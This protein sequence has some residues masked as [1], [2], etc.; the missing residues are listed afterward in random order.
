MTKRY[1]TLPLLC[2]SCPADVFLCFIK[3]SLDKVTAEEQLMGQELHKQ[4]RKGSK[5]QGEIQPTH[6]LIQHKKKTSLSVLERQENQ[7]LPGNAG[8]CDGIQVWLFHFHF[9][10]QRKQKLGQTT[11]AGFI[12]LVTSVKVCQHWVHLTGILEPDRIL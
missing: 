8:F 3:Q 4:G 7:I 5:N 9:T 2:C 1:R 12:S 10:F 6:N 11:A